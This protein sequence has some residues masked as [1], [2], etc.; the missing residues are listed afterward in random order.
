MAGAAAAGATGSVT[1]R[2]LPATETTTAAIRAVHLLVRRPV[3]IE[4][5]DAG[6]RVEVVLAM[7]ELPPVVATKRSIDRRLSIVA[8]DFPWADASAM[9]GGGNT[10]QMISIKILEQG[11]GKHFFPCICGLICIK[12]GVR[13]RSRARPGRQVVVRAVRGVG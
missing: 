6:G 13:D 11:L 1:G 4:E 5:R 7:T 2:T 9:G 10:A 12:P 8:V 3:L